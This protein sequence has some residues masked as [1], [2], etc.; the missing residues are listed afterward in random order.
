MPP[1]LP[2]HLGEPAGLLGV[3]LGKAGEE[4]GEGRAGEHG[5]DGGVEQAVLVLQGLQG[6]RGVE[7]QA[8]LVV[9]TF[10]LSTGQ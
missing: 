5:E 7:V 4:G 2:P 1:I 3:D 9:W 8:A 6:V 10:R